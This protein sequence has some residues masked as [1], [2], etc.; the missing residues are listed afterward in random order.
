[1]NI[2][3]ADGIATAGTT[4]RRHAKTTDHDGTILAEMARVADMKNDK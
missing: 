1:M 3:H 4:T 2:L